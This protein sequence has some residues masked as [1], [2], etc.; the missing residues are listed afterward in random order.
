M[1]PSSVRWVR[2]C[3]R[4]TK[5]PP[6]SASNSWIARD[7]DGWVTLHL[8]EARVKFSSSAIARK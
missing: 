3:S 8:S 1:R 5:S 4:C 7:S 2:L 6:S